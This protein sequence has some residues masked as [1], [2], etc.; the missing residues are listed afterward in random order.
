VNRPPPN[1][2]AEWLDH[3]RFDGDAQVK[4]KFLAELRRTRDKVLDNASWR[5]ARR[6]STS[7]A[8]RGSSASAHSSAERVI[9][10]R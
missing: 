9:C 6:F 8:A 2:W 1:C 10:E 7:A 4:E 3:R 5:R